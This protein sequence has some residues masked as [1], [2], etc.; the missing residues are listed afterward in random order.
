MFGLGA[1]ELL[2]VL[3]VLLLLFGGTQ[4]PKLARSIGRAQK[5]F[6]EGVSEGMTDDADAETP[7]EPEK[8]KRK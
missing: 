4:I 1:S 6:Q 7:A 8:K 3:I 2:I 5:E